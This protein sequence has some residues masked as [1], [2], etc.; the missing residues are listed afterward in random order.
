MPPL[1]T[2]SVI[3]PTLNA[4]RTLAMCLASIRGQDYPRELVEIVVADAGSTDGTLA[5]AESFGVDRVVDNPLKTGEA[6]KSAAIAAS[7]GDILALVDSDNIFDDRRYFMKAAKVFEDPAVHSAEPIGWT[8]DPGDTLVNRYC[9]LLGMND[10]VSLFLGNYNRYS[11]LSRSFTGMPVRVVRED[12]EAIIVDVDERRVPT[13]GANGFL[14]R[15]S[16]LEG[17][18]WTP[19]YFDID[20]FQQAV[21][22]GRGR[23][24]VLKTETRHLY[25]DSVAAF[26]RKQARRIRDYFFH[27]G[28]K[29]RTYEYSSVPARRY[30]WFVLATVTVLPLLAQSLRG[31]LHKRDGAWWFHPAACWITLWEY[32]M[33]TAASLFGRAKEYDR[34]GWRQ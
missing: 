12:G 7:T 22:A 32:G 28:G 9:A 27:A 24:G 23:I 25:C 11:H 20:V 34:R 33:G 14:V 29:R 5:V 8:F 18:D 1:P 10:P 4:E 17:L 19:Y 16:A 2:I 15:R 21:R 30:L 3:L 31:W 13:F 26:R 6:G